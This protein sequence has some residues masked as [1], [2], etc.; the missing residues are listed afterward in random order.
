M[1]FTRS[2]FVDKLYVST[3][4]LFTFFSPIITIDQR[5]TGYYYLQD[6]VEEIDSARIDQFSC[7]S[8][9]MMDIAL[10]MFSP[11]TT[12]YHGNISLPYMIFSLNQQ[13]PKMQS[14]DVGLWYMPF[15]SLHGPLLTV[16]AII[17]CV[18]AIKPGRFTETGMYE[19]IQKHKVGIVRKHRDTRQERK[20]GIRRSCFR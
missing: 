13:T 15:Y 6:I 17:A 3:M 4:F 9:N 8:S 16:Y 2:L 20:E 1:I 18:T 12:T 11:S 5:E 7:E 10:I 14:N 19:I